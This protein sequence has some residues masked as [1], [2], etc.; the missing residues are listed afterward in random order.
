VP[1]KRIGSGS[2][3]V[4]G[5]VAGGFNLTAGSNAIPGSINGGNSSAQV[6]GPFIG[7]VVASATEFIGT[8]VAS[9]ITRIRP[10]SIILL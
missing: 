8:V 6:I 7:V 2:G 9:A 4:I 1:L 10:I 5:T 3:A